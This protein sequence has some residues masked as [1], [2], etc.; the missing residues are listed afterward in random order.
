MKAKQRTLAFLL[1]L[2]LAA[3]AALALLTHANRKAEQAASEAADGSI[4]LLDVTGDTLEQV[5]VQYEGETLTCLR[6]H[7]HRA[8]RHEGKAPAR[9]TAR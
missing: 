6:H 8:G 5:T 9:G 2:V 3:G 7:P 4:P 1:V